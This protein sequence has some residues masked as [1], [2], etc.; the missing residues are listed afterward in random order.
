VLGFLFLIAS[1]VLLTVGSELF[2]EHAAAAG[3]RLGVT[4]LA[5]GLVLA[6]AEPE[7]M[8]TAILASGRHLP[9]VAGGD[10]IGANVTML[11]VVLGL[12]ALVR[13]FPLAGRVRTYALAATAAGFVAA[14]AL[15]TGEVGRAEGF[16]LVLAYVVAVGVIWNRERHPPTIGE[17]AE[18]EEELEEADETPTTRAVLLVLGGVVLMVGGGWLAVSGA[19][20][21]VQSLG[22][23]QSSV[24]LTFVALATTAELFALVI[25]AY[26]RGIAELALAGVLGSTL[27]NATATLGVAALVHPIPAN[28][29]VGPAWA[30]A[31]LPLV[32]VAYALVAG[33]IDRL[34]GVVL[35]VL[36]GG[37]LT[38]TLR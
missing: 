36:Y 17:M 14:L 23:S 6:G 13:P 24:G 22:I 3:R 10:A 25:A 30:A 18:V 9:G 19:E 15:S 16:G 8:V 28:G 20:R 27:Y 33:R 26:R 35:T 5:I 31:T 4:M 2:A 7:E 1:A 12:A 11:T 34:T 29:L 32:L 37:Y 21:M 38:L